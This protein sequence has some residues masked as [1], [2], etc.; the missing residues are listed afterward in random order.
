MA[1]DQKDLEKSSAVDVVSSTP[2][3]WAALLAYR[4]P[5]QEHALAC[6]GKA[7]AILAA[8]GIMSTIVARY[9]STVGNSLAQDPFLGK[10]V[11]GLMIGFSL[12]GV[13][14]IVQAFQT[15]LP[16]FPPAP[17]SLA[18]FGDILRLT[19]EQYIAEV[20]AM[21]DDQAL[22]HILIFNHTLSV[23][24]DQKLTH[25][26]RCMKLYQYAAFAWLGALL[27]LFVRGIIYG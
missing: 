26:V 27:M 24:L 7:A 19:R 17:R 14:S 11:L 9:S 1:A 2:S 8:L 15:L 10:V 3:D 18:F 12:L 25:V 22:E 6:D 21:P 13:L 4:T 16:R 5:L 20:E 23:I